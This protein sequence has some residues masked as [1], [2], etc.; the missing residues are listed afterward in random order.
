MRIVRTLYTNK[1][2]LAGIYGNNSVSGYYGKFKV[3]FN[4]PYASCSLQD[5]KVTCECVDWNLS[6]DEIPKYMLDRSEDLLQE[7]AL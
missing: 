1:P 5:A 7:A 3:V 6:F 2:I 4:L